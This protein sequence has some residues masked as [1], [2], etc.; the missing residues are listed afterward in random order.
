MLGMVGIVSIAQDARNSGTDTQ[1]CCSTA[2]DLVCMMCACH[3]AVCQSGTWYL[4]TFNTATVAHL[5]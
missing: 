5:S 3:V 1:V 2:E 4:P